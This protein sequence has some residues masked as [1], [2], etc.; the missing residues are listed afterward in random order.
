[1][2]SVLRD[3]LGTPVPAKV[4]VDRI[5]RVLVSVLKQAGFTKEF[6]TWQKGAVKVNLTIGAD[7][8]VARIRDGVTPVTLTVTS[9]AEA[10]A[11]A[12]VLS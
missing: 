11:L 1:M 3:L 7:A 6:S 2:A 9:S 4:D 5:N 8:V 10:H 12:E